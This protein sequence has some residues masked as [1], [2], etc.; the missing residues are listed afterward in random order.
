MMNDIVTENALLGSP[1]SDW[2]IEGY[3]DPSIQG[4]ATDISVNR[5][6]TVFFK[7]KTNATNYHIDIYRLGYYADMGARKVNSTPIL[8]SVALPQLQ[9]RCML[10]DEATK[11]VD[12]SNWQISASWQ[13][14]A[15]A[16]S[17][18]YLAKLVRLDTGG[19]S[20]IYF[21]VRDDAGTSDLL[22]QTPDTTWQAY[23]RYNDIPPDA[24][25]PPTSPA[26]L[27]SLYGEG[28]FD[29]AKRA[30]KVSYNRPLDTRSNDNQFRRTSMFVST[31]PMVRWIEANGYD[32]SYFTGV[33]SD[34]RGDLIKNH[35]VFLSVGHDEYWSGTQRDKVEAARNA[36]VHLAFF[37]G[38][39]VF[40]KTRWEDNHH[41]LVCYKETLENAKIDPT[42][43]WTGTWRDPRFSPPADGGRPENALTG[44]IFMVNGFRYD[45]MSVPE[46]DGKMRFWRNTSI[47]NLTP[48][49]QPISLATGCLGY[50]WDVDL[51]NQFRPAGLFHLS[52]TIF[53]N[54]SPQLLLDFGSTY[55]S[56]PATHHLTLYK[57]SS[58]ALVFGSGTIL[59]AWGLDKNHD[60]PDKDIISAP[61]PDPKMKQATVNLFAD[62]G[63]Q[64]ASLQ[65]GLTAATASTD[66]VAP[67][68]TIS[69]PASGTTVQSGS[70]VTI[71]GTA[72][73]TGGGVVGGVEVS[74]DGGTTWHPATGRSSWTYIWTPSTLGS[75]TIKSRAV[76]DSGNLET[77]NAGKTVTVVLRDCSSASPCSIWDSSITPTNPSIND[78]QPVELGVR[79]RSD[80][81]GFI[82]SIRFYKGNGNPGPHIG[83]LW[84]ST[85]KELLKQAPFPP[86]SETASGWQQVTFQTPVAISVGS[87]YVASY[88]TA[89]GNYATDNRFFTTAGVDNAPL[90][91]LKD[92]VSEA[93][94][95][96][97]YSP[98][99][100]FPDSTF[101]STNYW[102]DVLFTTTTTPDTTA[103]TVSATTP[104]SNA[105]NI[106]TGATVTVTFSEAMALATISTSTFELRGSA[107]ALVTA[108]V[109]YD[110]A[111]KTA[112]LTPSS[113]LAASTTHTATVK[114]GTNGVKDLA[115]NA[116]AANFSW[117]FTT[118]VA[119]STSI[120]IWPPTA[121]PTNPSFPDSGAVEVGVKFRS[122]V[123]GRI[124]GIR[125]YKGSENTG[126]HIGSLWDSTTKALLAQATFASETASG[127]QQVTFSTPVQIM[128]NTIYLASYHTNVGRYAADNSFFATAGVDNAPLHALSNGVSAGNG[129]F[130]YSATPTFPNSTFQ[131]T[132]YWVDVVFTTP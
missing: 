87:T 10:R 68:S 100:V 23:N 88:H 102:V 66:T 63:V 104:T 24:P 70:P 50:E 107:N 109:S 113:A 97:L 45:T 64:P 89:S 9:P 48:G 20:H 62:M 32:V 33:D 22:F 51:D 8:P 42:T 85:T 124:T 96:F 129:V 125:F 115:G 11:L 99:P 27:H 90:H 128:A 34:L 4:F 86:S 103:P 76:D 110:A 58:G 19:S 54:V 84:N 98:V 105:T 121:T 78:P 67:T 77:P 14:P 81:N 17:G 16:T 118:G 75:V 130:R 119:S 73:D 15:T 122:D 56:G 6:E 117:S 57:H 106:N 26:T 114:G 46:S 79:F 112:T 74:V 30:F 72:A 3:G 65:P 60:N 18:I 127:W 55:G 120:T 95:V 13:I 43:Q 126:Q 69:S 12:C 41:T 36:G 92:G 47:A 1:K 44:T 61:E 53:A 91:A 80:V 49:Q 132:N 2:D 29:L 123:N 39:E 5:G 52:T 59:W 116:L 101:Q 7:I 38:N 31:Y 35:K 108:T 25:D 28:S 94:G 37:S 93:N 111:S 21:V 82:T 83:S 131:S 71:S 40:W